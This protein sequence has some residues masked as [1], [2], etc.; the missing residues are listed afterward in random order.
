M[1]GSLRRLGLARLTTHHRRRPLPTSVWPLCFA[2][3]GAL[4]SAAGNN[5]GTM[6]SVGVTRG[7]ARAATRRK[8]RGEGN[9]CLCSSPPPAAAESP[10]QPPRIAR[11]SKGPGKAMRGLGETAQCAPAR[12]ACPQMAALACPTLWTAA[13]ATDLLSRC[14]FYLLAPL[15]CQ[16]CTV[17][18]TLRGGMVISNEAMFTR[19]GPGRRRARQDPAAC[20]S[21]TQATASR[22]GRKP[23]RC[24]LGPAVQS[25][26]HAWPSP[27]LA[28]PQRSTP[29][30]AHARWSRHAHPGPL[31]CPAAGECRARKQTRRPRH[32]VV[33]TISQASLSCTNMS[34]ECR[35]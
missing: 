21:V 14:L 18:S 30:H 8:R 33:Q 22:R 19:P 15:G 26:G 4:R 2:L 17:T 16:R 23:L 7:S 1:T 24:G 11:K 25:R 10:Y 6:S 9:T 29:L 3:A 27:G 12:L 5:S 28:G 13:R 35:R 31:R 32:A 20:D 34:G